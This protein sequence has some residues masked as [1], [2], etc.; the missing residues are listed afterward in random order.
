MEKSNLLVTIL[1]IAF[2]LPISAQVF[3][4]EISSG[5]LYAETKTLFP[6][7]LESTWRRAGWLTVSNTFKV[8][9]GFAI[10]MGLTYQERIPLEEFHFTSQNPSISGGSSGVL[11]G[12]WPTNPQNIGFNE[13]DWIRFPNF[14]YLGLEVI[15]SISFGKIWSITI[16]SGFYGN[17]LLNREETT[18]TPDHLGTRRADFGNLLDNV[19]DIQ[20]NNMEFGVIPK[21]SLRYQVSPRIQLG[22]HLKSYQSLTRLNDTNIQRNLELNLRWVAYAG[23]LSIKYSFA[24]P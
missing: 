2:C 6:N 24:S 21:V 13:E 9:K 18:V 16:G 4:P 7:T 11:I 23:G 8:K 19:A 14:K 15:P 3:S 17:F 1:L 5:I 22:I 12:N 10:E 20:Y